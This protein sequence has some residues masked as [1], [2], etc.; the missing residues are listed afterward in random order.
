MSSVNQPGCRGRL[1]TMNVI[2]GGLLSPKCRG[3][4]QQRRFHS[5]LLSLLKQSGLYHQNTDTYRLG[6]VHCQS[7]NNGPVTGLG[8][9]TR[10]DDRSSLI[11]LDGVHRG[12]VDQMRG[13]RDR[14]FSAPEMPSDGIGEL[15]ENRLGGERYGS[16]SSDTNSDYT[17]SSSSLSSQGI[18]SSS[19]GQSSFTSLNSQNSSVHGSSVSSVSELSN[20]VTASEYHRENIADDTAEVLVQDIVDLGNVSSEVSGSSFVVPESN[21]Q[22]WTESLVLSL[23]GQTGNNLP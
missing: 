11:V 18:Q 7:Q 9:V 3:K 13:N 12:N 10:R 15:R 22:D 2:H 19:D 1:S 14:A 21:Q 8:Y 4:H 16:V 17:H 6:D 20:G 5:P 23:L